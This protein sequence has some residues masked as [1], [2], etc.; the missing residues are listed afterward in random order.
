MAYM[1]VKHKVEDYKKWKTVYDGHESIRKKSGSKGAHLF[2]G[3]D[4]SNE[5]V[6]LFEWDSVENAKKFAASQDLRETMQKAGVVE[7][8]DIF[9]LDE[10]QKTSA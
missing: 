8:P 3:K 1:L 9:Y 10:V 4:N 7:M 2:R 6:I 5:L